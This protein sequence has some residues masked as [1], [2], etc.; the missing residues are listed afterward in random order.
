MDIINYIEQ[1]NKGNCWR[2]PFIFI[3]IYY[4]FF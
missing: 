1:I 2:I 3:M 4:N